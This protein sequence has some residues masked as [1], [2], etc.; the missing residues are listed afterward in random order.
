MKYLIILCSACLFFSCSSPTNTFPVI[1]PIEVPIV[2]EKVLGPEYN[3]FFGDFIYVDDRGFK[4]LVSFLGKDK[5]MAVCITINATVYFDYTFLLDKGTI[6][7][8]DGSC[9]IWWFE[10]KDFPY[11]WEDSNTLIVTDPVNNYVLTLRRR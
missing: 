4:V 6:T 10:C 11:R 5:A 1:T 9:I 2:P 7:T 8:H 3:A